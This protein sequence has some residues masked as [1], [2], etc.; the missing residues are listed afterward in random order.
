MDSQKQTVRYVTAHDGVRLA[1]AACGRGPAMVKGAHWITHLEYDWESPVWNHWM[2]FLTSNFTLIRYDERGNGLSQRDPEDVSEPHWLPDLESVVNAA[3][4]EEPMA[5]L[6]VSQGS[7]SCIK[8]AAKYPER[9]SHLVI[10]GGYARGYGERSNA[11]ALREFQAI[12]ELTELGWGRSEPLY[13][14]L[15]TNRFLPEGTEEQMAWF[16]RHCATTTDARMAAELLRSRL[17]IN[18]TDL[19]GEIKVPTLVVHAVGDRVA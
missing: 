17:H 1:W 11:E 14:R 4:P 18:V 7:V 15:F 9:V 6:G 13:R 3:M 5:L 16:D 10:Y 8:F 19:L 12:V 2:R